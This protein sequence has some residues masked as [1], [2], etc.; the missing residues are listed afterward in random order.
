[1]P[2]TS[3][4]V[5]PHFLVSNQ[6]VTLLMYYC[7][8]NAMKCKKCKREI[9]DNS[10]YCNWCGHKQLTD[11]TEVRVPVPT[12]RGNKYVAQV[13]VGGERVFV[14]GESEEEYYAKARAAKSGL[15][16]MKKAAPKLTLGTAID[17]YIK[18]N[19]AVL[20][21]STINAYKS[22]RKTRFKAFMD[23]DVSAINYQQMIN[24]E[25][26]LVKP[27][28]VHNAWRLVTAALA[29]AKVPICPVNLP[30]KCKVQRPW[31]DYEQIELFCKAIY[32]KP[33]E[34]GALLALNGLRRSE[35]LHLTADDIDTEHG[36]IFVRGAS[37]VGSNN[38]LVDKD[39][40]KTSS[41][42]R[43]VHIVIPRL[44]ELLKGKT[45]RLITTNPTTL[46]G[47]IN[48]LCEKYGLP[49]TGVHGLR[50]SY[51]SLCFHLG[52]NTQT[53][54]REGGYSNIQTVNNVY[55]HLAT[56]DANADIKR[57]QD[58]YGSKNGS[59]TL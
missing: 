32:G 5:I 48:G 40:N 31:L 4:A 50:H 33:Y 1:M 29:H 59:K 38:K 42:T 10:I 16:E 25:S 41:S 23:E 58:F 27:K 49:Q 24:E 9:P 22:Y 36:L 26:K 35:L 52:W 7:T 2:N 20:S 54:M 28:T 11:S 56:Q 44:N 8:D 51:I 46:Y 13:T 21:P 45:G 12:K 37:V 6:I 39:T 43:T 53:V 47:L 14:S 19:D 17:N 18:D 30:P 57:M 3:F 15:I 55:R 34:L